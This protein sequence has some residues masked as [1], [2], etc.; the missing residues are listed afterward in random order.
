MKWPVCAP[1][2]LIAS[3]TA[4]RTER[5]NR[6]S[7]SAGIS[8]A[9]RSGLSRARQRISS[10]SRL[11][12]P[13]ITPWSS[14]RAFSGAVPRPTRSRNT[15]RPTSAASGPTCEKSGSRTARPSRRLSRSASRP[16]SANSR[17]NRSQLRGAGASIDGEAAGHPEVQAELRPAVRLRPQELAAP[18]RLH[19]PVPDQRRGHLA[20][21]V[22]AADVRV[23]VVDRDDLAADDQLELPA[24]AFGLGQLGHATTRYDASYASFRRAASFACAF[25]SGTSTV[26]ATTR[27]APTSAAPTMNA[28]W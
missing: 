22:R 25:F 14:S 6:S 17:T 27:A 1:P 10:A 11:P 5:R 20:G 24:R 19:Q 3:R 9:G 18:V 15:S 8:P 12:T 7:S 21:R 23:A 28:S 4:A 26:A 13:E 16:P 2:F